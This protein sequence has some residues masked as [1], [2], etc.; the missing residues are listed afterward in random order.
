[1]RSCIHP[2]V[3]ARCAYANHVQ[4]EAVTARPDCADYAGLMYSNVILS[5]GCVT[6]PGFVKRFNRELRALV[7][8]D[9]DLHVH[10]PSDPQ[11]CAF[12]GGVALAASDSF[13]DL[14]FSREDYLE[15]G[16]ER[17]RRPLLPLVAE[18][19]QSS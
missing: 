11:S 10:V 18:S 1:M 7:P 5:G 2:R 3:L 9:M 19:I 17:L 4:V 13:D 14:A 16:S 15:H 6:I 8:N 12:A